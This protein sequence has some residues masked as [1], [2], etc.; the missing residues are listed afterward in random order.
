MVQSK[1]ARKQRK[2][3]YNAPLHIRRKNVSSHLSKELSK[4]YGL[5]SLQVRKGDTIRIMRGD[6]DILGMEG[7]V[8]AVFTRTGRVSVDGV[9]I[10]KADGTQTARPVHASKVEIIKL[11][12]SDPK[13][14][15]KLAKAKEVSQ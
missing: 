12:L 4:E 6:E 15:E 7:R 9:T 10:A 2:A 13:R 3:F 14:K 8:A 11:D 5:R 1:K